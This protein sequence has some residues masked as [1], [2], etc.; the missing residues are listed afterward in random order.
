[1][2]LDS[3]IESI[4]EKYEQKINDIYDMLNKTMDFLT[5]V[6]IDIEKIR[7]NFNF[8]NLDVDS[9]MNRISS[10]ISN[11]NAEEKTILYLNGISYNNALFIEEN[12]RNDFFNGEYEKVLNSIKK[13]L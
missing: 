4:Y 11:L 3:K 2:I 1:M 9:F 6:P 7:S 8:F 10:K 13:I 5:T 12:I